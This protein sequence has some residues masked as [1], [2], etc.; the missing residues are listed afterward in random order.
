MILRGTSRQIGLQHGELLKSR[1]QRSIDFYTDVTEQLNESERREEEEEILRLAEPFKKL[2]DNFE[3]QY[4]E[5]IEAIAEAASVNP[6]WIYA[7]NSRSEIMTN[8]FNA[9]FSECTGFYFSNARILA[10]NWDWAENFQDLAVI[11]RIENENGLEILQMTEPGIIGKIGLNNHGLGTVLNFLNCP[12][13]L[14]GIPIHIVLRAILDSENYDEAL[15]KIKMIKNGKSGNILFGD[16]NGKYCDIE[17]RG[18]QTFFLN[19]EMK[20]FLHTNHFIHDADLNLK[21]EDLQSS[22]MRYSAANTILEGLSNFDLEDA[23]T[24]LSDVSSTD[25]PICRRFVPGTTMKSVGTVCSIIMDLP[26]KQ[27]HITKGGPA[28]TGFECIQL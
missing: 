27:L 9:N 28:T 25:W 2:I 17:F 7:L 10:Q 24:I 6:L 14:D 15:A 8:R 20:Y 4:G 1:I 22:F 16:A 18:S 21:P 26:R 5:E 19:N 23:K 12:E 13:N 11:M 3:P